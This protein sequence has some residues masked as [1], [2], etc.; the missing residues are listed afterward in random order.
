MVL[1]PY[2]E[3]FSKLAFPSE[4]A[5]LMSVRRQLVWAFAW[6]VPASEAVAEIVSHGP[7]IEVGAGT[8]Y[9]AWLLR[10]AGADIV[11]YDRAVEAPPFW[12]EVS[13]GGP[14]RVAEH[15]DRTLFLCWPPMGEPLAADCLSVYRGERVLSIG[16]RG[17]AART[18]DARFR[19]LLARDFAE[20]RQLGL[21]CWPGFTDCLTVYQRIAPFPSTSAST[22]QVG[23]RQPS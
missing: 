18:G 7:L 5:R 11:A 16:E 6:A 13:L 4:S 10:Q 21:P 17:E 3:L 12:S 8:G 9:W 19:E 22:P 2:G 20:E 23:S 1:D 15:A 14:E